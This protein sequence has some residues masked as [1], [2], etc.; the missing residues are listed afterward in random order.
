MYW[1]ITII[2]W[3]LQA[4]VID[5]DRSCNDACRMFFGAEGCEVHV[6]GKT[7]P[8]EQVEYL[9]ELGDSGPD[10][11]QDKIRKTKDEH[12]T[13]KRSSD[14]LA[15]DEVV[16]TAS[17]GPQVLADLTSGTRIFCPKHDDKHASAMLVTSKR[18]QDG[19]YCR[20][21]R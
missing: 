13:T 9:I 15:D 5:G 12:Q 4:V 16:M 17:Q 14:A 3:F 2:L 20:Q 11:D 10:D 18:K 21:A 1:S 7:L 19:V 8:L 6:V